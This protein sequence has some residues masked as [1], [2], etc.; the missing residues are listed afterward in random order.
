[1]LSDL[2]NYFGILRQRLLVPTTATIGCR[3][4]RPQSSEHYDSVRF[5]GNPLGSAYFC[6]DVRNMFVG[7]LSGHPL[8]DKGSSKTSCGILLLFKRRHS[9]SAFTATMER[10]IRY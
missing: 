9:L 4:R 2:Q 1:M 6:E 3:R 8:Y 5:L 7:N 10:P